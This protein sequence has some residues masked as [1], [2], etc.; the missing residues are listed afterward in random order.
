[1]VP[2]RLCRLRHFVSLNPQ[3]LSSLRAAFTKAR[4][5]LSLA[6]TR[7]IPG[8]TGNGDNG[9]ETFPSCPGQSDG[10][11][12]VRVGDG[13]H[14]HRNALR[15]PAAPRRRM[16]ERHDAAACTSSG[17][18]ALQANPAAFATL[19]QIHLLIGNIEVGVDVS[20]VV[21]VLKQ[22]D[23]AKNLRRVLAFQ[24]NGR[25]RNHRRIGGGDR[26]FCRFDG[27]TDGPQSPRTRS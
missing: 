10:M 20:H 7:T 22:V 8:W 27:V 23:H 18:G 12:G 24:G 17:C 25:R 6:A 5:S 16:G 15:L 1:M 3:T 21:V 14:H 19:Q 26:D 4:G 13:A 11:R 9:R 2:P